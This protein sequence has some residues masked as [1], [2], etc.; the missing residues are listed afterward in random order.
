MGG[1]S[2]K[3]P[4]GT[5]LGERR[6]LSIDRQNRSPGATCLR[7]EGTKKRKKDKVT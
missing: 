1:I 2:P 4:K 7:D 5:Y 6:H 3:P